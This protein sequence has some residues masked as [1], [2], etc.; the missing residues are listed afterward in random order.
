M[1]TSHYVCHAQE[2]PRGHHILLQIPRAARGP[3]VAPRDFSVGPKASIAD[4][5]WLQAT[6]ARWRTL[7]ARA[8]TRPTLA[9][10]HLPLVA[11]RMES[12]TRYPKA[13]FHV[14]PCYYSGRHNAGP[15]ASHQLGG[16]P[17]AARGCGTC[18][19]VTSAWPCPMGLW[20]PCAPLRLGRECAR[21][22]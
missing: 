18:T 15:A 20:S 8:C 6:R 5:L 1:G 4:A 16:D 13:R 2:D 3:L 22:T 21:G 19:A 9:L 14:P 11:C 17:R 10:A 12:I 7:P